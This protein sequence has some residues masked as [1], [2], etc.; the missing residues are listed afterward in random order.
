MAVARNFLPEILESI[1]PLRDFTKKLACPTS[2]CRS[3]C[4]ASNGLFID[5]FHWRFGTIEASGSPQIKRENF[6][7][8]AV[9]KY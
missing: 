5:P 3:I 7:A 8:Q 4:L 9:Y 2:P 1:T 6:G